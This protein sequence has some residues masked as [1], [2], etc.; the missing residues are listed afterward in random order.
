MN[1]KII[2]DY[3]IK[4]SMIPKELLEFK[5]TYNTNKAEVKNFDNYINKLKQIYTF[6][7]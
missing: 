2:Y 5:F 1:K 3:L 6:K 4:S 7:L